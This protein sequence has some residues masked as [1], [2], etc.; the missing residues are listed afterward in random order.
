MN[1]DIDP[2]TLVTVVYNPKSAQEALAATAQEE[3]TEEVGATSLEDYRDLLLLAI[4]DAEVW[5]SQAERLIEKI[6]SGEKIKGTK[7][8]GAV[9]NGRKQ[10]LYSSLVD[11][12][13]AK[14]EG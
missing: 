12:S 13:S 14:L 7:L 6:D 11:V 4:N 2:A 9:R 10:A 8:N 3:V 1:P 5:V